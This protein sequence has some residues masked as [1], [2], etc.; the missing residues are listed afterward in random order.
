MNRNTLTPT[1]SQGERGVA[2]SCSRA[3]ELFPCA[4]RSLRR[5]GRLFPCAGQSLTQPAEV[6]AGLEPSTALWKRSMPC[7]NRPFPLSNE[8]LQRQ[9]QLPNSSGDPR[10]LQGKRIPWRRHAGTLSRQV[11]NWQGQPRNLQREA[12]PLQRRAFSLQTGRLVLTFSAFSLQK[13]SFRQRSPGPQ[14]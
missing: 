1:L 10:N 12:F 5:R 7:A 4:P 8:R 6:L 9:N 2:T 14:Q 3:N 13:R 11:G